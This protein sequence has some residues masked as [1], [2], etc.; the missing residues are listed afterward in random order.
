[1]G[2]LTHQHIF[3]LK[4]KTTRVVTT[5][6]SLLSLGQ[7]GLKRL[8]ALRSFPNNALCILGRRERAG[9]GNIP[10]LDFLLSTAMEEGDLS[11]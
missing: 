4:V 1:M 9:I 7:Q 8:V 3:L 10:S 5:G 11:T 2:L 6:I